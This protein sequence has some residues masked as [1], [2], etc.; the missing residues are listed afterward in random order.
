MT[1]QRATGIGGVFLRAKD[2]S[3]LRAWYAEHLGVE[4]SDWGGQ[5]FDWTAGGST[6][7]AVFEA[8]TEYF[9]RPEQAS[10]VNYRVED[11]DAMLAQLR[12]DGVRVADSVEDA[13]YGRFGWAYDCEGNRFELWQ[14]PRD[15]DR[16]SLGVG[17]AQLDSGLTVPESVRSRVILLGR[18]LPEILQVPAPGEHGFRKGVGEGPLQGIRTGYALCAVDVVLADAPQRVLGL[19]DEEAPRRPRD[20]GVDVGI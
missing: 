8:E 11:L 15:S 4:I 17:T 18:D 19:D 10:M 20:D 2:A 5:K 14:P 3:V 13:E 12:A 9:G 7:W 6:T 16:R 1:R